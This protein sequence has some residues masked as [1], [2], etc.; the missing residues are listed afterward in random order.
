MI[1]VSLLFAV[2]AYV[3]LLGI[4]IETSLHSNSVINNIKQGISYIF[5]TAYIHNL[6]PIALIMNFAFWS[7]FLLLPKVSNDQFSF[8]KISYSIL[9][10]AFALGGILGGWI[11]SKYL[12]RYKDKHRI[13]IYSLISQNIVLL[14]LGLNL[15]I[16]NGVT[17]YLFMLILWF[18]Y[19][20]INTI[21]SIIYFGSLQIKVP[22]KMIGSVF[23]SILTIFSLVNP[24][25][26]IVSGF[27]V[28]ILPI[29]ILIILFALIMIAAAITVQ[30]IPNLKKA[31]E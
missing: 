16:F 22:K 3:L 20:L 2:L 13:F 18:S 26:A 28:S 31:F 15:L 10:L 7:I 27:L 1:I 30:S 5:S 12:F 23:G 8:L 29:A 6:I 25:T 19:A 24:L 4:H 11:F 21:F 14:F 9:E 17:A